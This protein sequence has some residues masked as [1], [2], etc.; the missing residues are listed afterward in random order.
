[1]LFYIK[2]QHE[3]AISPPFGT[4]LPSPFPPHT[5]RLITEPLFEF[6]EPY[7]KFLLAIYFTYGNLN[8][9]VTLSM[10]LTL[11]SPLPLSIILFSYFFFKRLISSLLHPWKERKHSEIS[12]LFNL[13][14]FSL[15]FNISLYFKLFILNFKQQG[16]AV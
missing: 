4:S 3:S 12:V 10:Y 11:S 2:P 16:Y 1:M 8:F 5:S 14:W 6:P 9:H 13:Q 7:S 15:E